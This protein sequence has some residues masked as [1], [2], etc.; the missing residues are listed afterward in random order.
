MKIRRRRLRSKGIQSEIIE[1]LRI[2]RKRR[3]Q[4]LA[5]RQID[6]DLAEGV[7]TFEFRVTLELWQTR[8]RYAEE[9][10]LER[11]GECDFI[12]PQRSG[13]GDAWSG[14]LDS[15]EFAG[16]LPGPN[17]KVLYGEMEIVEVS[18]PS[19]DFGNGAREPAIFGVVR[20]VNHRDRLDHVDWQADCGIASGG[21]SHARAVDERTVLR[22]TA[23]FHVDEA[24][25]SA[26]YARHER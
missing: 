8:D 16:T 18:G 14:G 11:L 24:V 13:D 20:I 26:D 17:E 1:L 6:I 3:R 21:I 25:R 23:A 9:T 22:R 19:L 12:L 5:L 4:R 7:E 10:V 15:D 2:Q